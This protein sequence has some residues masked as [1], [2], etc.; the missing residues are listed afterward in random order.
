MGRKLVIGASGQI[1]AE[2]IDKLA[3]KYGDDQVIATDI[4][5][6]TSEQL[7]GVISL[8]MDVLDREHLLS[9]IKAM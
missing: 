8:Q 3:D 6:R 4:K 7:N 5:P 9:V 2:L 1:G